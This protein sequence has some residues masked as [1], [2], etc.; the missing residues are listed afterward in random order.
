[1]QK[2]L[3]DVFYL[4]VLGSAYRSLDFHLPKIGSNL[5]SFKLLLLKLSADNTDKIFIYVK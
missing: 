1:M 4:K 5:T 3:H 2:N